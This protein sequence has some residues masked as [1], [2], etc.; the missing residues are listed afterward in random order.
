MLLCAAAGCTCAVSATSHSKR[1]GSQPP[2]QPTHQ[3]HA[4]RSLAHIMRHAAVLQVWEVDG[5]ALQAHARHLLRAYA[6]EPSVQAR[7]AN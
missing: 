3:L 4:V 5:K 6:T 1:L 2:R 7:L